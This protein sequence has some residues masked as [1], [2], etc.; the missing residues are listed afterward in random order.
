MFRGC[1]ELTTVILPASLTSIGD[2]IFQDISEQ[3]VEAV[4]GVYFKGNAP[5]NVGSAAFRGAN[6]A[7]VYYRAGTTGWSS[8]LAG[9]P[10]AL[11][12]V[13]TYSEWA[14]SFGLPTQYPSAS[15]EQDDADQDGLTNIHEK[16]AGTDP[17]NAGSTLRMEQQ[18]RP[19][20]LTESDKTLPA[21]NQFALYFQ[22]IPGEIYELQST[23]ILGN[24]W[25]SAF[26]VIATTTQKRVLM[27]KPASKGFYHVFLSP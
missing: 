10:T 14:Q 6:N 25:K 2:F 16:E 15:G 8:T 23:P 4:T 19:D 9:R 11:W 1:P 12:I 13:P 22:S 18:P 7:I 26:T 3:G 17:T 20:D 5:T 24:P 21:P 27:S